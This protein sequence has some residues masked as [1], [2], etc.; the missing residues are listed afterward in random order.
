MGKRRAFLCGMAIPAGGLRPD[1]TRHLTR[2]AQSGARSYG[3]A[4]ALSRVLDA[5]M[6]CGFVGTLAGLVSGLLLCI[7][8]H[9]WIGAL[10]A[11]GPFLTL[12][13]LWHYYMR[14]P[15]P[16]P[17]PSIWDHI[18]TMTPHEMIDWMNQQ[19]DDLE[20]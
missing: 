8:N 14:Q 20:T 15:T 13:A 17:P 4:L 18:A 19:E 1:C 7:A 9:G 10:V 12:H 16:P 3:E 6:S 2:I 11:L 5:G